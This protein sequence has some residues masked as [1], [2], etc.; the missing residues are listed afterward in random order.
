MQ[1]WQ[2]TWRWQWRWR[3][4]WLWWGCGG[5]WVVQVVGWCV[6]L[7]SGEGE[8]RNSPYVISTTGSTGADMT[9]HFTSIFG[10][11]ATIAGEFTRR[12]SSRQNLLRMAA[13][14]AEQATGHNEC[15][16]TSPQTSLMHKL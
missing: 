6:T 4:R 10:F 14:A 12:S 15:D 5:W 8:E 7:S 9:S 2:Q 16:T 11:D 13:R 1:Q 3:R